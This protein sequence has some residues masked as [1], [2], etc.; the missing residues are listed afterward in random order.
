MIAP[1][2]GLEEHGELAP[3]MRWL[4]RVIRLAVWL[5][6][7]LMVAVIVAGVFQVVFQVYH[8]VASQDETLE[9]SETFGAFMTVLIAIEIFENIVVY[10]RSS[11]IRI[12]AVIATA[13]LAVARKIIV[14]DAAKIDAIYFFGGA[15]V[16]FA[17]AIA[18]WLVVNKSSD[19]ESTARRRTKRRPSKRSVPGHGIV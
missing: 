3:V 5:L 12:Q 9:I 7:F 14:M 1:D 18:Y 11:E 8:R 16:L 17:T 10:L 4:Q 2:H 15:A 13:L 6:A 19:P